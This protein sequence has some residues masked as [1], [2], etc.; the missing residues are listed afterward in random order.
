MFSCMMKV[1]FPFW[2]YRDGP[3]FLVQNITWFSFMKEVRW[4]R[5]I[6]GTWWLTQAAI[7]LLFPSSTLN[8]HFLNPIPYL[9]KN[10][11]DLMWMFKNFDKFL[12]WWMQSSSLLDGWFFHNNNGGEDWYFK[13]E[14][15]V[16]V[17]SK[18]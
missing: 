2:V 7:E 14:W 15:L 10:L 12:V 4:R 8:C 5:T 13:F 17:W 16:M 9:T 18:S 6:A 3:K 1:G 11:K